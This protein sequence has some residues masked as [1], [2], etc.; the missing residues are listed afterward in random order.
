MWKKVSQGQLKQYENISFKWVTSKEHRIGKNYKV[1]D[2]TVTSKTKIF[3]TVS[4]MI[5]QLNSSITSFLK[6]S[7][8]TSHQLSFFQ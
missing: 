5:Q 3:C 6:H 1:F 8:D 4:E 2:V 7:Y